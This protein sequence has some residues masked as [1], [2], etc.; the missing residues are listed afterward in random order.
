M[1]PNAIWP[2]ME[3]FIFQQRGRGVTRKTRRLMFCGIRFRRR[4]DPCA[5]RLSLSKNIN[6]TRRSRERGIKRMKYTMD[7]KK[8]LYVTIGVQ[9]AYFSSKKAILLVENT[10]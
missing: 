3:K 1:S 9:S 8:C 2:F 6:L 5:S 4:I 10:S 7:T